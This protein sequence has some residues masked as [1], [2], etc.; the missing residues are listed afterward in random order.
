LDIK[1][2][3]AKY[4]IKKHEIID[5]VF[6]CIYEQ[7]IEGVTMRSIAKEAK[8][9]QA[10]LHYYFESKENLLA[11]FIR[12]LFKR[13]IYDIEKR[14]K[15][16]DPPKKKLNYFFKAGKDFVEKDKEL[17][18]VL[19]DAWA[20]CIK[21]SSLQK[22]YANMN[23]EL[24]GVMKRIIEEGQKK[25]IFN[26]VSAENLSTIFIAFVVGFGCLWHMDKQSY[27]LKAHFN[28]VSNDLQRIILKTDL[29]KTS[30]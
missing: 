4:E 25:E 24:T 28:I 8:V 9:N 2:N 29:L 30:F 11:E 27:D 14:Y 23:K 12:M 3:L 1:F 6:K 16:I 15:A 20:Y 13:F 26:Q 19:I 17:F 10:L 18:V 5:A 21:D 22:H 7:G